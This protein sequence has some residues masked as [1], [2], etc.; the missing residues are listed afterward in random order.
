MVAGA[1]EDWKGGRF[2]SPK[3]MPLAA[4]E[5]LLR[6]FESSSNASSSS[7]AGIGVIGN[8]FFSKRKRLDQV[9]A[10]GND[11]FLLEAEV[12]APALRR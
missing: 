12:A 7:A 1:M 11:A 6:N 5:R 4:S 10:S 8:C 2:L 9:K 3:Q